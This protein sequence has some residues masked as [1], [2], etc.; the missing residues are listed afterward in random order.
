LRGDS[1]FH[2]VHFIGQKADEN[3][4]HHNGMRLWRQ[5]IF[6]SQVAACGAVQ[7]I[8]KRLPLPGLGKRFGFNSADGVDIV[9]TYG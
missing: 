5:E 3:I 4:G 9:E 2:D 6:R 1:D 8:D 7:L